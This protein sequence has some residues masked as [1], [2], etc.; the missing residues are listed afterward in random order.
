MIATSRQSAGGA[1]VPT[2]C[3]SL[4]H[5]LPAHARLRRAARVNLDHFSTGAFSLV[6]NHFQEYRPSCIVNRLRQHSG[7]Q[8]LHV[9][10]FDGDHAVLV[11]Q[12]TGEFVLEVAP[13]VADVNVRPLKQAYCLPPTVAALLPPRHLALTSAQVRFRVS[14]VPG[15][16]Y[17]RTIGQH[18]KAVQPN[19]DSGSAVAGRQRLRATL[20]A[21]A[22]E[23]AARFAFDRD[24]LNH[25]FQGTV[26]VD[27]NVTA[28][29]DAQFASVE[30]STADRKSTR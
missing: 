16:L 28:P 29:L 13:L 10:I 9:Q 18:G 3:E 8:S 27:F 2:I 12:L 5:S 1:I 19:V 26:Q 11:H 6:E 14:V 24:R 30:Q 7:A 22:H 21:K 15:V 20:Y 25:T 23:P 4:G 17:L